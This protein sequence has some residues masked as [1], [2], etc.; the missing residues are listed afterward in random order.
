MK[1]M[2]PLTTSSAIPGSDSELYVSFSPHI[3]SNNE[4][5][6]HPLRNSVGSILES[7]GHLCMIED[8]TTLHR[9][10]YDRWC[11]ATTVLQ[12]PSLVCLSLFCCY[13]KG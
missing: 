12:A 11:I 7:N 6:L 2:P 9:L 1:H 5:D 13:H 4:S 8:S 3:K 10:Y